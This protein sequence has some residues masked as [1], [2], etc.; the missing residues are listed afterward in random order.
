MEAG[1]AH[2]LGRV[3]ARSGKPPV[4][5]CDGDASLGEEC[6]RAL[7]QNP[8]I[9]QVHLHDFRF[10]GAEA[11]CSFL[12]SATSITS[13]LL[14]DIAFPL[15]TR[16]QSEYD[17]ALA[18][19]RNT[20][21]IATL[22]LFHMGHTTFV[23]PSVRNHNVHPFHIHVNRFQ[24]KEMGSELS[25]EKYP[26]LKTVLDFDKDAWRDTVVVPPNGRTRIW[27]QYKNYTGKTVFHCHFLAHEDTGMMST[28][29]IGPQDEFFEWRE[30]LE[31]LLIAGVIILGSLV[32][33]LAYRLYVCSE[34]TAYEPVTMNEL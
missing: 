9:R 15:A 10:Q 22:T 7:Q 30:H 23:A 25:T 12:D 33:C 28:L 34:M 19:Q 21:S 31:L 2:G 13:L 18:L 16:D 8:A 1:T 27:V 14:C 32:L 11:I 3:A 4:I 26:V 24:V 6:L 17:L 20:P 5:G 29:F